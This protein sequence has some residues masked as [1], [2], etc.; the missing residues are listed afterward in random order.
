MATV[1]EDGGLSNADKRRIAAEV[2]Y[3]KILEAKTKPRFS[4]VRL[5]VALFVVWLLVLLLGSLSNAVG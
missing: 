2:E 5:V 1:Q 4:L 3:R